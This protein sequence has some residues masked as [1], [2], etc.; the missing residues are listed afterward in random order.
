MS[1]QSLY[2]HIHTIKT[3]KIKP[4]S[5]HQ[6]PGS[7]IH[8][9][10]FIFVPPAEFRNEFPSPRSDLICPSR[11]NQ[12]E[13]LFSLLQTIALSYPPRRPRHLLSPQ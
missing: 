5:D 4:E 11:P 7:K 1:P 12:D 13:N 9:H 2:T 3:K 6:Y 8:T 10:L